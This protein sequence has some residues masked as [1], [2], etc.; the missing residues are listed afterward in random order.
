MLDICM[1]IYVFAYV[2]VARYM[3]APPPPGSDA[4]PPRPRPGSGA[5]A[6]IW[7]GA[8]ARARSPGVVSSRRARSAS[9]AE[10]VAELA[11][12]AGTCMI[13]LQI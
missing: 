12:V 3:C 7:N 8:P 10:A 13:Y 11:T 9:G 2:C 5:R 6:F 4:M 1:C